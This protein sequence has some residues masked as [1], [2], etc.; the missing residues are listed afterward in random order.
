MIFFYVNWCPYCKTALPEWES[1]STQ[2]ADKLIPNTNYY[3]TFT[4][5]DCTVESGDV[6]NMIKK[7]N[8]EAYPTIVLLKGNEIIDYDAKPTVS[9]MTQ[10]LS[11]ALQ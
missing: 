11:S 7:Y 4:S 3:V 5:Y 8:V 1:L 2:Y 6:E 10:F 9:T